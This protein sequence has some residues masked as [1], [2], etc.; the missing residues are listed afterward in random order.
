VAEVADVSDLRPASEAR[1][2]DV[3][4][5]VE[6]AGLEEDVEVSARDGSGDAVVVRLVQVVPVLREAGLPLLA[7]EKD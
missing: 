6:G 2:E 5:G 1:A 4:V 3:A 7:S